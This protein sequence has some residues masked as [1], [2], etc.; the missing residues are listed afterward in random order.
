MG[1]KVHM[2]YWR[3]TQAIAILPLLLLIFIP[4]AALSYG[5]RTDV[6]NSW[7]GGN[8]SISG[9]VYSV[10]TKPAGWTSDRKYLMWRDQSAISIPANNYSLNAALAYNGFD[11]YYKA[12]FWMTLIFTLLDAA[13]ITI[14]FI[15]FA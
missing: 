14:S 3:M 9:S 5:T 7:Y 8:L 13:L 1:G 6:Y 15:P 10:T 4:I 11:N 12:A 2:I